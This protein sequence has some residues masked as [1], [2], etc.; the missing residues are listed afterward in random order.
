MI[1]KDEPL[2]DHEDS[3]Q[4]TDQLLTDVPDEY[5]DSAP[6]EASPIATGSLP[7]G[8][9]LV[10]VNRGPNRGAK[11]LLDRPV[12]SV[13]RH[14]DSD[15]Y[16]DDVTVSRRHA[17]FRR[18]G[19]QFLIADVGSLNGTYRNGESIDTAPLTDGDEILIGKFRLTF[20]GHPFCITTGIPNA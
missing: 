20:L 13:G 11:F 2:P 12:T 9:G 5:P 7:R 18:D 8:A 10:V 14:V 6:E 3:R 15:I 16:L 1:D 4:A 19:H 17:E